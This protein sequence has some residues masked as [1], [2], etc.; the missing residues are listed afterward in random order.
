MMS[1][2]NCKWLNV[3]PRKDGKIVPRKG[4]SYRCLVPVPP[5]PEMP[6][7]ITIHMSHRTAGYGYGNLVWPEH[8]GYMRVEDGEG[9][10]F[11]SVRERRDTT[12]SE[13]KE[14]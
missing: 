8:G 2:R 12:S 4:E 13:S 10:A 6:K 1:C 3:A 11:F 5:P 14:R 7:S 9:C